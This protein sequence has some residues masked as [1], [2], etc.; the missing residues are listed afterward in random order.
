MTEA[1]EHAHEHE[2]FRTPELVCQHGSL[3]RSCCIC[4]LAAEVTRLTGALENAQGELGF[5]KNDVMNARYFE[6]RATTELK[7]LRAALVSLRDRWRNP[8][9]WKEDGSLMDSLDGAKELDKILA[10]DERRAW[11]GRKLDKR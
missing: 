3:R 1:Y 2:G 5:M 4:E 8:E 11:H 7:A 10:G 6:V 9:F